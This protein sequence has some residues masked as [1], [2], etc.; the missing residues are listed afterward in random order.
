MFLLEYYGLRPKKHFTLPKLESF[1]NSL[2]KVHNLLSDINFW[3]RLIGKTLLLAIKTTETY[4]GLIY[5]SLDSI[6]L[7]YDQFEVRS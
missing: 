7:I 2:R 4:C 1:L 5:T 6:F 3:T